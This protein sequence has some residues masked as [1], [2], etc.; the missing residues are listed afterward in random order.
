DIR[1]GVVREAHRS[2]P[3]MSHLRVGAMFVKEALQLL[4][5]ARRRPLLFADLFIRGGV[6]P[7]ADEKAPVR[8][9]APVAVT[10]VGI[11]RPL[12]NPAGDRRRGE[13]LTAHRPHPQGHEML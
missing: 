4:L 2:G 7:A 10:A 13:H 8:P 3:P 12:E 6:A 9:L 1:K 11:S 5:D